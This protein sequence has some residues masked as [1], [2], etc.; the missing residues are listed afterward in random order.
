MRRA[1]Q[2]P[3]GVQDLLP[4]EFRQ[5][6]RVGAAVQAV[7]ERWGYEPVTTPAFERLEVL[8]AAA[9]WVP[10]DRLY[11]LYDREGT[12]LALRPEMTTPLCRVAATRLKDAP[13]PIRLC[14]LADVFRFEEPQAGRRRQFRQ[15][16]VELFGVRGPQADAEVIA[17]A[18]TALAATGVKEAFFDVGHVEFVRG[19]TDFGPGNESAAQAIRRALCE[20]DYVAL[21]QEAAQADIG[22]A[23][24][25]ALMALPHLRGGAE[26]LE[27]ARRLVEHVRASARC[28]AAIDELSAVLAMLDPYSLDGQVRLD[29]GLLRD[30][31]YYSGMVFEG[32]AAEVGVPLCTG[33]RYDPLTAVFG[34]ARPATGFA[35][36]LERILF[37]LER[38]AAAAPSGAEPVRIVRLVVERAEPEVWRFAVR[39][40][41]R[42]RAAGLRVAL[43]CGTPSGHA[44]ATVRVSGVGELW[45]MGEGDAAPERVEPEEVPLRAS[46]R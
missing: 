30:I 42:W 38:Q 2:T 15:A 31:D 36:G 29:L 11:T 16:G 6:E 46:P 34:L 43:D 8:A 27:T 33:G 4:D 41:E 20:R 19:L 5:R 45:W 28:L 32:Y 44:G 21:A 17:L 13:E 24:R 3:R 37:A 39:T 40:A 10:E 18:V 23:E 9:G 12:P 35:L 26:V 25:R 1:R 7:F 14:Y 22:A